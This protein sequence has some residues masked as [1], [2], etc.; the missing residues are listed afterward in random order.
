M[1][2]RYCKWGG[3]KSTGLELS[4]SSS[5]EGNSGSDQ[6]NAGRGA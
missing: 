3:T 4:L 6:R 2:Q 1:K 5:V